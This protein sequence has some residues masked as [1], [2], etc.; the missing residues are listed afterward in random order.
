MI[1]GGN[2]STHEFFY[3]IDTQRKASSTTPPK[4]LVF[5]TLAKTNVLSGFELKYLQNSDR[6]SECVTSY[7]TEETLLVR[8]IKPYQNFAY[9]NNCDRKLT[10]RLFWF[11]KRRFGLKEFRRRGGA[12]RI[13]T[14]CRA[15]CTVLVW[16]LQKCSR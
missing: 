6:D 14:A 10:E 2:S 15:Q 11:R 1:G 5:T 9:V 12:G 3:K 7:S 13:T 8:L 16:N 4:T